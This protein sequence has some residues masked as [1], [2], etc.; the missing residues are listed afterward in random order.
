MTRK[1]A[2]GAAALFLVLARPVSPGPSVSKMRG[3]CWEGAG[4]VDGRSLDPLVSIHADWISQ[5]PFG[6]CRSLSST[7]VVLST[8]HRVYWGESDEGLAETARLARAR[9]IKTLLKPHLW[10]GRGEWAGD[11]KM[12]S[13]PEWEAWFASYE[14]FILHYAALAEREKMDAL[15]V[16]TELSKSTPRASDWRRLISRVRSVYRGPVTYCANWQEADSIAFWDALD[17]IG[18][19][20][21]YPVAAKARPSLPEIR[22]AWLPVASRLEALSKTT[23]KS[24]AFTEVGYK[25]V[26]GALIEPWKWD[27]GGPPD[28]ELQRDAYRAMFDVFWDRPWFA[29]TFIWKWHPY[30]KSGPAGS[31]RPGEFSNPG[32][33]D[34]TPQGKPASE[35]LREVYGKPDSGPSRPAGLDRPPPG[36]L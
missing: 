12:G 13:E 23:G 36:K 21:Y 7:Q 19:Q 25:S 15:A 18:I 29:G 9:G 5:T 26:T 11:L 2:A 31:R 30:F 27:D 24:I 10:I 34:F 1:G 16:G 32:A 3:V 4:T 22:S 28:F 6:W 17:F 33:S 8:N 14:K 20:A 35:V